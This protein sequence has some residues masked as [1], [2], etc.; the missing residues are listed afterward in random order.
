MQPIIGGLD[1]TQGSLTKKL[2]MMGWPVTLSF[3][4]QTM[5]N[6]ADA[7]WLGKLGKT[8]LVAPTITMNIF[9]IALSLAMGLGMGGST[10]VAQYKGAGR[11]AE[12]RRAGGQSLVLLVIAGILLSVLIF[13]IA[14]PILR[15]LQT[16]SDAFQQTLDYMRLILVGIPF[17]FIY[18]VYQGISAGI[19]DT[20]SPLR[21]N[22][23][24]VLLN[25]VLDPFLI[26]G[27]GPFPQMGVVGAALATCL[28]QA[29]AAG[30]CLH[31]LFRGRQGFH[32]RR[33]D[34]RW[35]RTMT[36]RIL[37]I[38]VPVS[39]G[40]VG[41]ALGFTLLLGIVNTFGSAVTAAFGI[42]HRIIHVALAPAIG[43]SQS[44][45]TSVGQNLGANQVRRA[46]RSVY[47]SALMLGVVLLPATSLTFFFGDFISRLFVSDPEVVQYGRDLFRITSFSVF[48]FGFITI[49]M[50]A[51]RGAGHT[52]PFMILNMGRLWLVRVPGAYLLAKVLQLG[53]LGLWWAMFLSNMLTAIAGTIWFSLGTWKKAVIDSRPADDLSEN[54]LDDDTKSEVDARG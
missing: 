32:L 31:R 16:P 40:Q 21:V 43:L 3:L 51:F 27:I 15:L 9:F 14:A 23:T 39:L 1:F 28:A 49:L 4:L 20:I 48:V 30:L 50:G 18:F 44:C 34:L 45:A 36:G 26:F 29:V 17:M 42:G 35:N 33:S 5:H 24:T 6:L 7:F 47:T 53:P 46:T 19:G 11:L 10:L 54:P 13:S 38:G 37:K 25:V 52:V 22:A 8:A 12:M 41:S 2:L